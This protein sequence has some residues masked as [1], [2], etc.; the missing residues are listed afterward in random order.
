MTTKKIDTSDG[1]KTDNRERARLLYA[2]GLSVTQ[3]SKE[4]NE[5]RPTVASWKKRDAWVRASIFENV[6]AAMQARMLALIGMKNKGNAEYKEY[7][8]FMKQL[9]RTAKI[10]RYNEGGNGAEL[11]PNLSKRYKE[12]RKPAVKNLFTEE[13]ID[14]L[15]DAFKLLI[16]PYKF[17]QRWVEILDGNKKHRA[18]RIFMM[19]KS[20]QIGATY[21]I[22][23]W[24]LINALRTKKNKIFLS[25]SKAQAYQFIEYIKAFVFEVLGRNIG[26]EPIVLS[27]EDN[28]QVSLYY[29][30]T[31][32]LTA[33]GRHGDVIMDEFFWIRKFKEFRA[34]A[35]G[36]ASQ[37]HFQQVY[38]STPSSV[39]HEAYAFWT[40]KDGVNK[41]DIDTSHSAL[42]SGRYCDDGKW[43]LIVTIKDAIRGGF[44]KLDI[45]QL[46]LEYT[47][48]RFANLFMC[49][50]LDDS[51]SYFPLSVL[52]PNMV[53]SWQIW[54]DFTP[55]GSKKFAKPVWVGYDPSFTGDRP[56]LAVIAPP[57][58]EGQPYRV[59]ERIHLDH[60]PPHVQA[61]HIKKI[62]E[63]YDVEFLGIDTTG[64]G[65][66]VAEHVKKF[67]PN[68]T[69]INY[70]VESKTRMA[71]RAKE[72]FT[73]RKLHFD[74]G[75]IDIAKAFIA[76]KQALTGSQRQM[77]FVSSRSK[78]TGHS[79]VAWAI[80]N[81]L[82]KAPLASTDQ[83]NDGVNKSR[84]GVHR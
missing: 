77:T 52:Q 70:S 19:L 54:D 40:G 48:E 71:L 63:R 83:I 1:V 36:M 39:L 61:Q 35:S 22:A 25:A 14:A 3:I 84:I 4:L 44:D 78:E 9:E 80:M 16:Q 5:K 64:A 29:M 51:N 56:A 72:L 32:A 20:R 57:E 17:Q 74:A 66:S 53:D 67:F 10:K 45:A 62:C 21:V 6:E 81:A 79:D 30:G 60:M 41:K 58:K 42:K 13:E 24:A 82:E 7:D 15:E 33:Q 65:I 50:F 28:T 34:V 68:Y 59:L 8:F 11:N 46:L 43:R 23:I 38:L 49:V 37:S 18:A 47:P 55:M 12:D 2:Q 73:R 75:S 31:N 76:I 69:A 27:L 26:G